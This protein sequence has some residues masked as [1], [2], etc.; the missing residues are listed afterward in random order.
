MWFQ[1]RAHV[2]LYPSAKVEGVFRVGTKEI[3]H[4]RLFMYMGAV[5]YLVPFVQ[6]GTFRGV[7]YIQKQL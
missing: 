4:F 6:S 5:N 7:L 2:H 3:Y 1:F